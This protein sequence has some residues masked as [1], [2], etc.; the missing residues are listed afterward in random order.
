L[1][2]LTTVSGQRHC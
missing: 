1:R 2:K